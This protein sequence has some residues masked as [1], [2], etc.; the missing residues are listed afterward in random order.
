MSTY[1]VVARALTKLRRLL[2]DDDDDV[3]LIENHNMWVTK[4]ISILIRKQP[5][6]HKYKMK[7]NRKKY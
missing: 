6:R 1:F 4:S 5:V 7:S 2:T 3:Y